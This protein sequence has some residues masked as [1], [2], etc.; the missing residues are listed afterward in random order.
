MVSLP[1]PDIPKDFEVTSWNSSSISLAWDCPENQ[2]YSL[3]LLTVF[4]LNGT[5]HIKEEVPLW[6]RE[7]SLAFTLFD[8]QPCTR[9]R[10]GL[11]TVCRAG[12]ESRY[13]RMVLNDGNSGKFEPFTDQM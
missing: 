12:A 8:L 7:D 11:Q 5:D 3:F 1:D 13:S 2:K 10:F 6:H 4:Y 9:V